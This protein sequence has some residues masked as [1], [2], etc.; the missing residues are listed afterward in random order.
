[1]QNIARLWAFALG[2]GLLSGISCATAMDW[3]Q[4]RGPNRDGISQESGWSTI[5]PTAGPNR[6][7][8]RQLGEGCSAISVAGGRAYTMGFKGGSD[9]VYCLDAST[10]EP[11]WEFSYPASLDPKLFEGGP[12]ST[13]VIRDGL[14]YTV[15]RAGEL[16][17]LD[18]AT[19]R[20]V[21]S[22][23][24]R[25][26]FA[27]R[28]PDWGYAAS[29]LVLDQWL[30]AEPGARGASLVAYDRKTGK[31]AWKSGDFAPGYGSPV[32]FARDGETLV[33]TFNA[34]GLCLWGAAAGA[35]RGD[36]RWETNYD[37]NAATPIHHQGKIFISS[38]Y[39]AGCALIDV[40]KSAPEILWQIKEMRNKHT[41][42]VLWEGHLY[43]FDEA[44]L[45]CMEFATGAVKWR[46]RRLGRGALMLADRKLILQAEAGDLVIAAASPARFEKIASGRLLSSR[47][48]VMPVLSSA[49]IYCRSNKGQVVCVDAAGG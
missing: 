49:K 27:A 41:A 21:W 9:R 3:P 39:G 18:A 17:C 5:W 25:K 19:G 7:W 42:C 15:S 20:R 1:M 6:L 32:A 29:P 13:P 35:H 2:T 23:D 43:G 45:V 12:T 38:G 11:I 8:E 4:W 31:V 24:W 46:E 44:D 14:V 36:V 34:H 26:E 33:A 28:P 22:T 37:V 16:H 48:W 47:S 40:T 30:I 10:G